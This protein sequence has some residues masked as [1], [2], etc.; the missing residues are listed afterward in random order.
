MT[1]FMIYSGLSKIRILPGKPFI[2]ARPFI[3]MAWYKF[4]EWFKEEGML[5]MQCGCTHLNVTCEE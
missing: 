5:D 1:L 2:V 3:D 4:R